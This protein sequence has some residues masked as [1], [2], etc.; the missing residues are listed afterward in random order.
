MKAICFADSDAGPVL[1]EKELPQAK[2]RHSELLVRVYAA[3]M[4]LTEAAWY[5]TSHTKNGG[6]RTGAVPAH[7]F[8]GEIADLGD[9]VEGSLNR[10]RNL[11]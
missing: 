6:R 3:G 4:T 1:V 10:P 7:E 5:P 2:P 11:R 9:G 8:S